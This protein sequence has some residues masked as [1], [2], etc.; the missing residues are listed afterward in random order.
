MTSEKFWSWSP[1]S[2][3]TDFLIQCGD[4]TAVYGSSPT[5]VETRTIAPNVRRL[6]MR[7]NAKHPRH[8][9]SELITC[10]SIARLR[11]TKREPPRGGL[12]RAA[13]GLDLLTR[14]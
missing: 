6:L 5:I 4:V 12:L 2:A 3:N 10:A 14:C 8:E 11:T 7:P 1:A 9:K 13:S